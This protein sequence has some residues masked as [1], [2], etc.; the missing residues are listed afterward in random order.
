VRLPSQ[1]SVIANG[2]RAERFV[3]RLPADR[4][5]AAGPPGSPLRAGPLTAHATFPESASPPLLEH[6]KVR[7]GAGNVV[8]IAARHWLEIPGGPATAWALSIPSRGTL[9]LTGTGESSGAVEAA[10][11]A[12]GYRA[13][14]P[15]SGDLTIVLAGAAA[16]RSVAGSREFAGLAVQYTETWNITGVSESGEVRGTVEL[17]TTGRRSQ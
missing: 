1:T 2:G 7:D 14:A 3:I 10:L 6:F 4:I 8:G 5:H 17:D 13:G 16:T 15:W 12:R 9:I 11:A